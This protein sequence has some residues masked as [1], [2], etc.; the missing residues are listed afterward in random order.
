[1]NRQRIV[2]GMFLLGIVAFA[3][4]AVSQDQADAQKAI[5]NESARQAAAQAAA[6]AAS[7]KQ[8][9]DLNSKMA[10][11][12]KDPRVEM[13]AAADQAEMKH[14]AEIKRLFEAFQEA[15]AEFQSDAEKFHQAIGVQASLKGPATKLESTTTALLDYIKRTNLAHPRFDASEFKGFTASQLGAESITTA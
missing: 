1:M 11:F 10:D 5:A 9:Q 15:A 7:K 3:R 4:P 2:F 6:E 14:N 13:Q 12:L 8:L